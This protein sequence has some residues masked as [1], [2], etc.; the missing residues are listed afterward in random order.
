MLVPLIRT[1]QRHIPQAQLTWVISRPAY[2]LVEGL[3]GVE[4]IVIDKPNSLRDFWRFKQHMQSR[5]FDVLLAPQASFRTN[6]L[7]PLIRAKRKIGYDNHRANDGHRWF[8]TEQIT[9]GSEHTLEGFLKFSE[10]L[11]VKERVIAWNIPISAED[12]AWADSHL[13]QDG[14]LL[15]VNPAASKPERSWM[16]ERYIEVLNEAQAR[17]SVR[18]V[19]TGGPSAYDHHLAEKISQSISV[20]NLVGKT[21][22]KQL[23]AVISKAA[24]VLCPDTGPSHMATAVTTPVIALHAVTNPFVSGPYLSPHLVVNRY[25]QASAEILGVPYERHVWGTHVH[26]EEA[27]GLISVPDVLEQLEKIF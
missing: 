12:H 16:V 24:V 9:P 14:P 1:L 3:D 25:P 6:L 26:G 27:M 20:V 22:P 15:V 4:F 8:V 13:P 2:D 19:L 21:K 5:S 10:P 18:V 7:Y 17:W 23:L 11:G